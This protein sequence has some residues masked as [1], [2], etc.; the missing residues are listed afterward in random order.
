MK[1]PLSNLQPESLW[2]HF[3]AITQIPHPSGHT[4][5]IRDYLLDFGKTHKLETKADK[6]GN[7]FIRKPATHGKELAKT[8]ILQAHMDM[9]PQKNAGVSHDF[10]TDS[11]QVYV[12]GDWVKAK[13]TTLGADN[14]IGVAAILAV[15]ESTKIKHGPITALFTNDEETGMHGVFGLKNDSVQ[16]DI[17]MNLDSEDEGELFV[18]CAGGIDANFTF[19]YKPVPAST[20]DIAVKVSVTGLLGG[21][22]GVDIH[23]ERANANK[24]LIRF[25]KIAIAQYEARLA[26]VNGGSLRNAIPREAF[27]V[28]T[29]PPNGFDEL[30]DLAHETVQM[31]NNEYDGIEKKIRLEIEKISMV[32]GIFPEEVQDDLVN[33]IYASPNGVFNHIPHM[34]SVV[35]SSTNLA[36]VKTENDSIVVKCLIRS[37]VESKIYELCSMHESV[38]ALAGAKVEFLGGYPGW[39]PKF[40][41]PVLEKMTA[42]YTKKWKKAP[43]IKV[44]H[45]GLECGI[46]G[47]LNPQL[48]MISFGPTIR[49]PHSPDEKVHIPSVGKFWDFLLACLESVS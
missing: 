25:L 30:Q 49:F 5:R 9:V 15:L 10:E 48:D 32:E 31:F 26:S 3:Y 16:G 14:G 37:S 33:A 36:I 24:L 4:E 17:L 42:I 40:N 43:E 6:A 7:V 44:I 34:P 23:L 13:D 12:D 22:S 18:G 27:A 35:E 8:V 47:A 20:A 41:S 28:I 46:I 39:E 21:H 11:L 45:A 38:F 29:I 19:W 2:R 1:N